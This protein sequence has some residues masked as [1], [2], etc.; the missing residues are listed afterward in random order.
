M[1]RVLIL[2]LLSSL[3]FLSCEPEKEDN[4]PKSSPT[5]NYRA[6][7]SFTGTNDTVGQGDTVRFGVT[8]IKGTD[9][10]AAFLVRVAFDG[11]SAYEQRDS[12]AIQ[13]D[14]I[15]FEK[16]IVTRNQAGSEKWMFGLQEVDGD[17]YFRP[18]T[19]T[20]Q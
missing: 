11:Q 6:D 12:I 20:V 4:S 19:L 16:Q 9:D 10:M 2:A 3:L 17:N 15:Y 14:T 7:S 8:V 1:V 5:I 18:I 13:S